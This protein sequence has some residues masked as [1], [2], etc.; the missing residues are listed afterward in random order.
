M[1]AV[2]ALVRRS[3]FQR[4]HLFA[5]S[6]SA[7]VGRECCPIEVT[8]C[9]V[10]EALEDGTLP[11]EFAHVAAAMP[12]CV[13]RLLVQGVDPQSVSLEELLDD[14]KLDTLREAD[15]MGVPNV[16]NAATCAACRQLVDKECKTDVDTVDGCPDYQVNVTYEQL[17]GLIGSAAARS[18]CV[19]LPVA[20]CERNPSVHRP[21]VV[22]ELRRQ[23]LRMEVFLRRYTA[24]S[25]PWIPFHSDRAALTVN[26]ALS[27]ESA[28][29]GGRLLAALGDR[30]AAISRGEGEAT[31][32]DSRLLHAVSR[33]TGGARYSLICF[34]GDKEVGST[35]EE[36]SD[37]AFAQFV[38]GLSTAKRQQ[39]VAELERVEAPA[40]EAVVQARARLDDSRAH[41]HHAHEQVELV[42]KLIEA[43]QQQLL[44]AQNAL[45]LTEERARQA[46]E[47]E[48]QARESVQTV[49]SEMAVTRRAARERLMRCG[50]PSRAGAAAGDE[51]AS[52][53]REQLV[54]TLQAEAEGGGEGVGNLERE[55]MEAMVTRRP[56]LKPILTMPPHE[57]QSALEPY[58]EDVGAVMQEVLSRRRQH[59]HG[60]TKPTK[61]S[62]KMQTPMPQDTVESTQW[63]AGARVRIRGLQSA[64]Q[65]NGKVG[66]LLGQTE[67]GREKVQL[68]GVEAG[69]LVKRD[70]LVLLGYDGVEREG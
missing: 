16:L 18:I 4:A 22:E 70:H 11:S 49:R 58:Q 21:E 40:Q 66:I 12:P 65:H 62:P 38:G 35:E 20:L 19:E 30:L 64:A 2:D 39:L 27:D 54:A 45:E 13:R 8:R 67:K 14:L 46:E 47:V 15:V 36:R 6:D 31:L 52:K 25:R 43:A 59:L 57:V 28:H 53:E 32:H 60:T 29:K 10:G 37:E 7:P 50:L 41:V 51:K 23:K 5:S 1:M 63:R 55:L 3:A 17:A 33:T 44:C 56:E 34:L 24:E 26:V 9:D 48:R 61:P 42:T 69:L 68:D